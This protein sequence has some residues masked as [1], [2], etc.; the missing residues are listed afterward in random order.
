MMYTKDVT[1]L[2]KMIFMTQHEISWDAKKQCENADLST[3]D[4]D[5]R[6]VLISMKN[7]FIIY[8]QYYLEERTTET[9]INYFTF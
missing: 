8:I 3:Y 6:R 1:L 5:S 7:I 2:S 9:S 4:W